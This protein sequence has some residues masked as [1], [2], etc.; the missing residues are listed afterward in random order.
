MKRMFLIRA[1]ISSPILNSIVQLKSLLIT[2]EPF[3][4]FKKLF[5]VLEKKPGLIPNTFTLFAR[6]E[7]SD[8]TT[9]PEILIAVEV[10]NG[11]L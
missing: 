11:S 1:M 9:V 4:F 3:S 10:F 2:A 8:F 6:K 7:L 5:D